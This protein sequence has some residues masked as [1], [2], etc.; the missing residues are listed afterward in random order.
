MS[1][2][3]SLPRPALLAGAATVAAALA[4]PAA[5]QADAIAFI[6]DHNVWLASPD[7]AVRHQ[8]TLDGTADVP[9]RSPSQADDGTLVAVRLRNEIVRL[10]QNGEVLNRISP[11]PAT[12]SNGGVADAVATAAISPD[13][14]TIAYALSS[15]TC[16]V[17]STCGARTV[18]GYTAADRLTD[19]A[20]RSGAIHYGDPSWVSSTRT[21]VFGGYGA[22]VNVHDLGPGTVQR[23]WYDDQELLAD[24][25]APGEDQGDGE[26]TRQGD[27]LAVVRSYGANA[28]VHVLR[29]AGDPRTDAD[30]ANPVGV[31]ESAPVEGTNGPTWSPDGGALAWADPR[32][33][34]IARGIP[35]DSAGCAAVSETIA[36]PGASE[37]DWGPAA[38]A[39]GPRPTTGGGGVP[40]G[41]AVP[42]GGG[43]APGGG[44]A[45]PAPRLTVS[46]TTVRLAT[47]RRRGVLL[48]V[49]APGAGRLTAT[50][51][52][53]GRTVLRGTLAVRR[54]G[55]VRLRLRLASSAAARRVRG[56]RLAVRVAFTPASGAAV[57][58][59]VTVRV[60]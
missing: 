59:T 38:I 33:I 19:R 26:L 40:G 56:R 36:F 23:H 24:P 35:V 2:R 4:A 37:P 12:T 18:T 13:G 43:G 16:P 51:K 10:R 32:G 7:G 45:T 46:G 53:R 47:L 25:A 42:S 30:P 44:T 8:V 57:V 49:R 6:Q 27:K 31:C 48:S 17:A 39:P 5:A 54:G 52:V 60:R 14:A 11:P 20:E 9:Y 55:A 41:G 29:T 34:T 15:Y 1:S 28:R 22:Q 50:A 3:P 58:R 21:L